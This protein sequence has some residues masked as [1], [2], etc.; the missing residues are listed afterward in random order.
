MANF[1]TA[2]FHP[3]QSYDSKRCCDVS[4]K[5][6]FPR[7]TFLP[8]GNILNHRP[9]A[10]PRKLFEDCKNAAYKELAPTMMILES[11]WASFK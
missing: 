1:I 4:S 10:D 5:D 8:T 7:D 2:E 3:K 9:N 6:M 11:P